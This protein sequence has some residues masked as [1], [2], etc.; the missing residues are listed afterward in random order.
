MFKGVIRHNNN[1]LLLSVGQK[2]I[3][4]FKIKNNVHKKSASIST[5]VQPK[6][7]LSSPPA[8]AHHCPLLLYVVAAVHRRCSSSLYIA[9]VRR[10]CTSSLS[11]T[12]IG[13]RHPSLLSVVAICR[14]CP[15]SLSS[16]LPIVGS[17]CLSMSV[18]CPPSVDIN[19]GWLLL[20][21]ISQSS[22]VVVIMGQ[23]P[24][25]RDSLEKI[26]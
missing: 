23:L 14:H 5:E 19:I 9:A 25:R 7:T 24:P 6:N 26:W 21:F 17:H 20:L 12:A 16:S 22:S 13:C 3:L 8:V 2:S 1:F 15:S 18:C 10:R 11:I 4:P